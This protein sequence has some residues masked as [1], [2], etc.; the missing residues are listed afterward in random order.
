MKLDIQLIG[1]VNTFERITKARVKDCF[2]DKNKN[3][4]FLVK[5][6]DLWKAVGKKGA[7]VQKLSNMLKKKIRIIEFSDDVK[8]FVRNVIMPFK[9]DE[10]VEEDGKVVLKSKDSKVKGLII[11]RDKKN[12][13]ELNSIVKKYFNVEVVVEQYTKGL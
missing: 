7:N 1:F 11:G 12:L 8:K 3:L 4:V 6:G 10:I 9:V 2:F 13:E 5:E